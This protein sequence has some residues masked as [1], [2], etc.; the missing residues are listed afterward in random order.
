MSYTKTFQKVSVL[1]L[2]LAAAPAF[3]QFRNGDFALALP[4]HAGQ[5]RW[6]APGFK[7][8]QHSAKP[9]GSE[10]GV[11]AS[12]ESGS[13]V[14]LA[15][16][17][18]VAE[19]APLTAVKCRDK[20][21]DAE[22]KHNSKLQITATTDGSP[23]VASYTVQGGGKTYS[24]VRAFVANGDV[25]GDLDFYSDKPLGVEDTEVKK[26]LATYLLD[27]AYVPK[28]LD[29]FL[30]AQLLYSSQQY[31]AAG[32]VYESAL[33]K[34]KANPAEIPSGAKP[35]RKTMIRVL[36]DQ[37]G[38]SYG[39]SSNTAKARAIFEKAIA[40]DP[41]YPM[42][43]YNLACADAEEKNLT[44]ARQHLTEAYARKA[45]VNAGEQMPDPTT[46]DSFLP[47]RGNKEFWSFVESLKP[48]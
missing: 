48:R 11:R 19:P 33:Q 42:Y 16:L 43:Y 31:R 20:V 30:Y 44:G 7:P 3:G 9:D 8:V 37:A 2:A 32:P 39:M 34:L 23:A 4:D 28:Y 25:C 27:E 1:A 13:I 45:N 17:F 35:D 47:Y 36:T 22:M 5:L 12:N 6:S 26:T 14:F 10:L 41:D 40:E 29:G 21:M 18:R 38:M 24:N 15:F 46:D